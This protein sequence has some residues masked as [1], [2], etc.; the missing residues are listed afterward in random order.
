M[1]NSS[2]PNGTKVTIN[3]CVS[4]GTVTG[5]DKVGGILGGDTYVAQT[6]DNCQYSLRNIPS[7]EKSRLLVKMLPI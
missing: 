3:N 2:A 7:Q 1:M 5:A 4:E 6:W